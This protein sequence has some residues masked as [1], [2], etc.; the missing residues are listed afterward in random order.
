MME[1]ARTSETLVN[2]YQTTRC[3]NPEDSRIRTHR[4][5]NLKSYMVLFYSWQCSPASFHSVVVNK[6]CWGHV[7]IPHMCCRVY[8][9]DL[10]FPF[11]CNISTINSFLSCVLQQFW[12]YGHATW[13]SHDVKSVYSTKELCLCLSKVYRRSQ[14]R[15]NRVLLLLLFIYCNWVCTR[16]QWSLHYTITTKNIQ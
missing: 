1:A 5:E 9:H 2:F 16:W 3:Y 15:I 4:R 10:M 11:V 13:S 14:Y 6:L 7:K 8:L 12:I